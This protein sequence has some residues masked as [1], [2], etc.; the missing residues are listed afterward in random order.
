MI[1]VLTKDNVFIELP[2][3]TEMYQDSN[4]TWWWK[5][6]FKIDSKIISN[7]N[8]DKYS[9]IYKDGESLSIQ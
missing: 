7:P 6:F 1:L 2:A 8:F 3:K 9:K 4:K 5:D